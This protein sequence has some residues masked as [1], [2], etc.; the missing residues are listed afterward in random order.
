[1]NSQEANKSRLP[2]QLLLGIAIGGIATAAVTFGVSSLTKDNSSFSGDELS[3]AT[4]WESDDTPSSPDGAGASSMKR[5]LDEGPLGSLLQHQGNFGLSVAL[6][7]TLASAGETELL[8]LLEQSTAIEHASR[9]QLVQGTIFRRYASLDPKNAIK[10]VSNMPRLQHGDLL[11]IVFGEWALSQLDDA[12]ASAKRLDGFGKLAALRGILESRD[13]LSD[14]VRVE[15][16]RQL[17]NERVAQNIVTQSNISEAI[18]DPESAWTTLIEDDL[19]DT[20][21]TGTLIQVA[22]A[23]IEKD[24]MSVLGKINDT[25]SDWTSKTSVL[26][27]VVHNLVQ[28][29]AQ[30]VFDFVRTMEN[31]THNTVITNVVNAWARLDPEAA[32]AAVLSVESKSLRASLENSIASSWGRTNPRE[33]LENLDL[34]PENARDAARSSA[35]TALAQ[36]SPEEAANLMAGMDGGEYQLMTAFQ[37]MSVWANKDPIAALEWTLNN[38]EVEDLRTSLLPSILYQVASR[39]PQLAFDIALQQPVGENQIGL[40]AQVIANIAYSN[41]EKALALL[42]QV[43]EGPT[44]AYALNS[45]GSALVRSGDID[46]AWMLAQRLSESQREAYYQSVVSAWASHDATELYESIDKLPSDEIKSLAAMRLISF[47]KWSR[48]LDEDQVNRAKTYLNERD[49]NSIEQ[50]SQGVGYRLGSE[51]VHVSGAAVS[52]AAIYVD[53][54]EPED[55]EDSE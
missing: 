20:A 11:A 39:N 33:A 37:V 53:A 49:A 15:I 8:S 23:W 10:Q 12:L 36:T 35:I 7:N 16:G 13:D 27:A 2:L 17:G 52:G 45:V 34:L 48:Q 50:M 55:S 4:H 44:L 9:R 26:A 43:R 46:E 25:L 38:P 30:A 22:E 29:D 40:E 3:I 51:F 6:H 5:S 47:N 21:Q 41:I 31:D 18:K 19:L 24:G 1:M 28:A 32:L 14:A 54:A 42:S